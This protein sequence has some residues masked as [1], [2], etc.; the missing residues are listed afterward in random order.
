MCAEHAAIAML[1]P[2]HAASVI[3]AAVATDVTTSAACTLQVSGVVFT[4]ACEPY[5]E[6]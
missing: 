1:R 3:N 6:S 2:N 4:I 5:L